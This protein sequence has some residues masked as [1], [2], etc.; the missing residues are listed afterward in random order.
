M[1]DQNQDSVPEKNAQAILSAD[2]MQIICRKVM[3]VME[4]EKLYLKPDLSLWEL[5]RAAGV[6]TANISKSINRFMGVNYYEL[7]NRMRLDEAR[8]LMREGGKMNIEDVAHKSGYRSRS[9]F[10]EQFTRCEKMTP[11]K[12]MS[13]YMK[14]EN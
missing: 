9:A 12:Y 14:N 8:R 6:N 11:K 2:D 1:A 7:L 4:N 3:D 5:S 13:L 10:Y